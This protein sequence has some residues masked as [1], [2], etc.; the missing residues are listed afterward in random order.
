[1]FIIISIIH[2]TRTPA[3]Y[4][5]HKGKKPPANKIRNYPFQD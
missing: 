1:M 4:K 3:L 5:K 2:I